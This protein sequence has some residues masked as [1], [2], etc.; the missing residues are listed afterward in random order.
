MKTRLIEKQGSGDGLCGI[1]AIANYIK[2]D[3][4]FQEPDELWPPFWYLLE[5]MQAEGLLQPHYIWSGLETYHLKAVLDRVCLRLNLPFVS[6]SI[7][8]AL[9]RLNRR[10]FVDL[11]SDLFEQNGG[12]IVGFEEGQQHWVLAYDKSKQL[13]FVDDS[14]ADG[15]K[16]I[17]I[18]Q[19]CSLSNDGLLILKKG[20]ALAVDLNA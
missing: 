15:R 11:T 2:N 1:Y 13:I 10:H 9:K 17:T 8:E 5:A 7:A 19:A 18:N 6:C 12:A 16:Q 20:S 14:A 4:R 3:T